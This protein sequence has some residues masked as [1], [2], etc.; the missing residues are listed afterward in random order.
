[1]IDVFSEGARA[2]NEEEVGRT[3]LVLVEGTSKKSSA[4]WAGRTDTNKRVVFE[5]KPVATSASSSGEAQLVPGDY[6]AVR[7]GEAISANTLRGV[8]LARTSIAEFADAGRASYA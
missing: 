3:H 6:V 4:E 8:P 1:M 2:S 7:V 5:R